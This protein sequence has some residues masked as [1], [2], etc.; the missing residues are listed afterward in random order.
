MSHV[1]CGVR[2]MS[3]GHDKATRERRLAV[4]N[5]VRVWQKNSHVSSSLSGRQGGLPKL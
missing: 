1:W 5:G 2:A 3:R 4:M